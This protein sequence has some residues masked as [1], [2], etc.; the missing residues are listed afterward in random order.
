MKV[1]N[2]IKQ[3]GCRFD[4]LFYY[5]RAYL[6]LFNSFFGCT[7]WCTIF[8]QTIKKYKKTHQ[9]SKSANPLFFKRYEDMRSYNTSYK[10]GLQITIPSFMI[11]YPHPKMLLFQAFSPFSYILAV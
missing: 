3:K 5:I 11:S 8:L 2:G 1:F 6:L 9:I 4:I 10:I 7:I